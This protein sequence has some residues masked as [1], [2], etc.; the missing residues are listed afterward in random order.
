MAKTRYHDTMNRLSI[1]ILILCLYA[2]VGAGCRTNNVTQNG[3]SPIPTSNGVQESL[4]WLPPPPQE[5]DRNTRNREELLAAFEAFQHV[6]S[7]RAKLDINGNDG[8][9]KGRIDVTKP[10]RFRGLLQADKQTYEVIGVAETVYLRLPEGRWIPINS[11][12]ITESLTRA[13]RS[14]IDGNESLTKLPITDDA[15]VTKRVDMDRK[16]TRYETTLNPQ[17]KATRTVLGICIANELPILIEAKTG[18]GNVMI[19]YFDYNSVF[20]IERP[21]IR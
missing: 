8:A 3:L 20:T 16:C 17:D 13:F 15:I 18:Q 7:F 6:K 5:K 4:V 19:D 11:P 9:V 21:T 10:D 1:F 14:A 2:I 12:S